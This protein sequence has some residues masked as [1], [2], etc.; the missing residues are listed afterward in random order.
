MS[1]ERQRARATREAEAA[2]LRAKK[3]RAAE[4]KARVERLTPTVP[5]LPKRQPVYRQRRFPKL[6]WRLKLALTLGWLFAAAAILYLAPTWTG[7]IG[8][9]VVAT[10]VLPLIVV[11]TTDPTRRTR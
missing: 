8:L 10:M 6:P 4:R 3:A 5:E 9:L 2:Q 1:K 7:R 11:I